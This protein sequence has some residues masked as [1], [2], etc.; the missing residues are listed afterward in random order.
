MLHELARSPEWLEQVVA[1]LDAETAGGPASEEQLMSGLPVLEQ[2]L[3]ETLRLYPAVP[4]GMRRAEVDVELARTRVP[5]GATVM[6]SSYATHHLAELYDDPHAFRPERMSRELKAQLPKGGYVPFG[7]GRRICVGKRFG[8]L[9]AKVMASRVLQ[10]F[11]LQAASSEPRRVRW[12]AT[13][14][15]VGGVPMVVRR[16]S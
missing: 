9:E 3:D 15:P 16:R 13:L 12:A 8:Y 6:Y 14:V 4:A 2:V 1:E 10:R 11:S 5:A 7:G